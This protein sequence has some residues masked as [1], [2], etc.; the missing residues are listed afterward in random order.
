[1]SVLLALAACGPTQETG[2]HPRAHSD[3]G[4]NNLDGTVCVSPKDSDGDGISD[5]FEGAF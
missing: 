1:M 3:G 5:E 4:A 2:F